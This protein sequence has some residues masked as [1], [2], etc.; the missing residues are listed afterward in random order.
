[1]LP[2]EPGSIERQVAIS[3]TYIAFIFWTNEF[4]CHIF[5]KQQ[6]GKK[7][8]CANEVMAI[9]MQREKALLAGTS[10]KEKVDSDISECLADKTKQN[11]IHSESTYS[12]QGTSLVVAKHGKRKKLARLDFLGAKGVA[13]L[14]SDYRIIDGPQI[15]AK[16]DSFDKAYQ[17][18]KDQEPLQAK[19]KERQPT[20]Q[21][22]PAM[23]VLEPTRSLHRPWL[24]LL[25]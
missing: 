15:I 6:E 12:S 4:Q 23:P 11:S 14:S 8:F 20:A 1:L 21:T 24:M 2:C 19:R 13:H 3:V 18:D 10:G 17:D 5:E 22:K 9:V 7:H 25:N 16:Q